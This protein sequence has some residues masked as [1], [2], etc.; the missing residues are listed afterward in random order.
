MAGKSRKS[1]KRR[2]PEVDGA[3][4][5]FHSTL[6][7]SRNQSAVD[8]SLSSYYQV[9]VNF[10]MCEILRIHAAGQLLSEHHDNTVQA[11]ASTIIH[12][13]AK[14]A[15]FSSHAA[16]DAFGRPT[17]KITISNACESSLAPSMSR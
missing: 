7:R 12:S 11:K 16:L 13:F 9:F 17:A 6:R 8:I 2:V 3:C 14:L 1:C 15:S 4:L 5:T 10:V